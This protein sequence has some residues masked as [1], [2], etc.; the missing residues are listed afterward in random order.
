MKAAL[1]VPLVLLATLAS[2]APRPMTVEDVATMTSLSQ[3]RLSPDGRRVAFVVLEA[4]LDRSR[5]QTDIWLVGADGSRALPL[6]HSRENDRAPQWAP[7]G[8]L[9]FLSDRGGSMQI[10][11]IDPAGGEASPLTQHPSS[12]GSYRWSPDGRSI[13]FVARDTEQPEIAERRRARDDARV[14][15]AGARHEHLWVFDLETRKSRKVT[16]GDY[17]VFEYDWA[18]DG[19]TFAI[20]KST[21]TGLPDKFRSDLFLIDARGGELT[22]LVVQPGTDTN[23]RFSPDG[24][25]IAFVTGQGKADWAADDDLAVVPAGGGAPK[26]ISADYDR[27]VEQYTWAADSRAIYWS[28]PWN[29]R[30]QLF[31]VGIDGSGFTDISRVAGVATDA[32][33]LP[34][35]DLVAYVFESLNEPPEIFISPL[36]RFAPR[37]L[38]D[39]NA[40]YRELQRA[41]R[42]VVRWT[43]PQ[44]GLQ[45]EGI[46][47]LPAGYRGGERVPLLTFVHG[48]PSSQFSEEFLGYLAHVYPVHIFA[49]RGYAVLQ[50]NPRGSG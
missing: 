29:L 31:R 35:R 15:G 4:D 12:I 46:L 25:W 27:H 6:A 47:T 11:I 44:D 1:L 18:P 9:A 10:W 42:R 37:R 3:P 41:E 43:N 38:T 2:A 5:Y 16:G 17:T 14:V 40:R 19:R 45:I 39:L 50:P 21:G 7:D 23:P 34:S 30:E 20:A 8:R 33:F 13:A 32:H 36:S 22:P 24:R 26:I 49:A 28:G 48:G